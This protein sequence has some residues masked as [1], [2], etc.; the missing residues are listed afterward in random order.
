MPLIYQ[1][2]LTIALTTALSILLGFLTN[3]NAVFFFLFTGGIIITWEN[4]DEK[5]WPTTYKQAKDLFVRT[6]VKRH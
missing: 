3:S 5:F 2:L 1:K 4:L 6:F